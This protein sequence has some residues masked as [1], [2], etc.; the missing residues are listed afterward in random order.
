M[1]V[2]TEI[3]IKRR[4]INRLSV[5]LKSLT[6]D[7]E[8]SEIYKLLF[9]KTSDLKAI[10]YKVVFKPNTKPEDHKIASFTI[11]FVNQEDKTTELSIGKEEEF[12][13]YYTLLKDNY[14]NVN[15]PNES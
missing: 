4:E 6:R 1:D 14:R 10:V 5:E 15:F 11:T 8:E 3:T 2:D 13:K 9:V 7:I 12:N